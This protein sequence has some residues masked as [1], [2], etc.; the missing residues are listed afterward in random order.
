[1]GHTSIIKGNIVDS[2]L[3]GCDMCGAKRNSLIKIEVVAHNSTP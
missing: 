2:K 1:M 3:I